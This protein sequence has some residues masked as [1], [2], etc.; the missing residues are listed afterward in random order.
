MTD[1]RRDFFSCSLARTYSAGTA[2]GVPS[3]AGD[4][5]SVVLGGVIDDDAAV[6]FS[7]CILA[8]TY[9][10]GTDVGVPIMGGHGS[11]AFRDG[12]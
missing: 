5:R 12:G 1:G 4:E 2:I 10:A 6:F 9:S 3:D 8:K 7:A 11:L